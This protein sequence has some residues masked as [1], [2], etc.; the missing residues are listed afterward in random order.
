MMKNSN[1]DKLAKDILKSSYLE[2]TDPDFNVTTMKKILR[3]SRKQR[4][5][6]N[7]LLCFLVFVA[8]DSLIFLVL[9]LSG[10][11]IFELTIRL[12]GMPHEI[13]FHIEKLKNSIIENS[14]IKYV[15]LSF[16]GIMVLLMI[17]ESKLKLLEKPK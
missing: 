15:M 12:I 5:L 13:L 2:I 1:I 8:V 9:W 10:L 3:E 17:I 4:V 7:I 16:G 6:E 11:N 14:F